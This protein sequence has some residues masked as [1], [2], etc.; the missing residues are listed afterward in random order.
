MTDFQRKNSQLARQILDGARQRYTLRR[1]H[2]SAWGIDVYWYPFTLEDEMRLGEYIDN[3]DPRGW[4][5]IVVRKALDAEGDPI[6]IFDDAHTLASRES[7][8]VLRELGAQ[9]ADVMDAGDAKK[10]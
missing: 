6:F 9:M 2:V 1:A 8:S 3:N 4:A 10:K 5:E 7:A